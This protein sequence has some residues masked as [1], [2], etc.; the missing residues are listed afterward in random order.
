MFTAEKKTAEYSHIPDGT[1]LI[2]AEADK[3]LCGVNRACTVIKH[4]VIVEIR[5]LVELPD[6]QRHWLPE[7]S[8]V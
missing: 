8:P 4:Q 2:A 5:Y 3:Y 7:D 1:E 6:G